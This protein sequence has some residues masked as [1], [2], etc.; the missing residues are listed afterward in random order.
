MMMVESVFEHDFVHFLSEVYLLRPLSSLSSEVTNI[1]TA[2][3]FL[4]GMLVTKPK[5]NYYQILRAI[6]Y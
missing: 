4:E 6:M 3:E 1:L 5:P 2:S